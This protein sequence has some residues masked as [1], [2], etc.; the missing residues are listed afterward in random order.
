MLEDFVYPMVVYSDTE[1]G[2]TVWRGNFSGLHGCWLEASSKDEVLRLAPSVL[3][4]YVASCLAA[5]WRLPEPPNVHELIEADAGEVH[6]VS[7][8]MPK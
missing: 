2:N 4:E 3:G 6:L 7:A 5:G 1:E 8:V